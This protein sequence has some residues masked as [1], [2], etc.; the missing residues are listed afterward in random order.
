[1]EN[2]PQSRFDDKRMSREEARKAAADVRRARMRGDPRIVRGDPG[3]AYQEPVVYG[4]LASGEQAPPNPP[5]P[6]PGPNRNQNQARRKKKKRNKQRRKTNAQLQSQVQSLQGRLRNMMARG[7]FNITPYTALFT[8]A[9][10][11]PPRLQ[12]NAVGTTAALQ[13]QH[14]WRHTM[15]YAPKAISRLC[16]MNE[17]VGK[18]LPVYVRYVGMHVT[19]VASSFCDLVF[20]RT[21]LTTAAISGGVLGQAAI[22]ADYPNRIRIRKGE[23]ATVYLSMTGAGPRESRNI[24]TRRSKLGLLP[25]TLRGVSG[26]A[27]GAVINYAPAVANPPIVGIPAGNIEGTCLTATA[28]LITNDNDEGVEAR[29]LFK[30][31]GSQFPQEPAISLSIDPVTFDP[32]EFEQGRDDTHR[33][34]IAAEVTI[35]RVDW[36]CVG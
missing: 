33:V 16:L 6:P 28:D 31:D 17:V 2:Y 29:R 20:D 26:A 34:A 35:H 7:N 8:S 24:I 18:S 3:F 22:V 21:G 9:V 13:E 14:K 4:G 19:I 12:A 1:M 15:L 27:P 36:L 23:T 32:S 25:N 30:F 10:T 11:F 5:Q